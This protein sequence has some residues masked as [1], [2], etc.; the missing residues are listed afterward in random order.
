LGRT[1]ERRRGEDFSLFVLHVTGIF[2]LFATFAN[3]APSNGTFRM[4]PTYLPLS[5]KRSN[6]IT[7]FADVARQL[8]PPAWMKHVK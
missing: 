7:T 3:D 5:Y 1:G 6:E 2:N 8:L 4:V